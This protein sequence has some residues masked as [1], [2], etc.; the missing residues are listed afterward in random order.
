MTDAL[1]GRARVLEIGVYRRR[2]GFAVGVVA[3]IL[4][5]VGWWAAGIGALVGLLFFLAMTRRMQ[6]TLRRPEGSRPGG[7][8]IMAGIQGAT[9]A[10]FIFIAVIVGGT[11]VVACCAAMCTQTFAFLSLMFLFT[12]PRQL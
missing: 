11:F 9:A 3:V 2:L 7:L 4:F 10:V 12:K 1:N 5:A 6:G 8:W